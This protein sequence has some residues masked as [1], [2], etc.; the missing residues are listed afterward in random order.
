MPTPSD[1]VDRVR[2]VYATCSTYR[3]SGEATTVFIRG[4][5][6]TDRRTKVLEF[7]TAFVRP[8]RFYFE[9]M[10]RDL[11]LRSDWHRYVV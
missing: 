5:R 11:G 7:R 9:F 4:P 6:P 3:D 10:N 2:G 1:I 8:D